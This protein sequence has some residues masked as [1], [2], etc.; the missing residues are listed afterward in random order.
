MERGYTRRRLPRDVYKRQLLMAAVGVTN[1]LLIN[2]MQK[3][4]V[5]AMYKSVGLSNRQHAVMALAEAFS[6]GLIGA[7]VAAFVSWL[8]IGT[9]F[10]VAGPK[11]QM[12]PALDA[13]VFCRAGL[14]GIAVTLLGSCL[15]Y[16]SPS[17]TE[18]TCIVLILS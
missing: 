10:L 13:A 17:P 5:T 14:L 12:A 18:Y 15:L 7:A 16:T 3:R 6:S 8:E 11:I 4:R 1:N 2:Y 9:I